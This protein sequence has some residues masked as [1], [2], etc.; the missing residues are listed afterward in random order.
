MVNDADEKV[1]IPGFYDDVIPL[2]QAERD[3]WAKLP[4]DEGRF[5]RD[6]KID[7]PLGEKG[8]SAIERSWARPTC[9]INGLTS[10][11]QGHGAKTIIPSTASAKVSMRLVPNQDPLKIG[12]S[13]EKMLR[14]LEPK[15]ATG[16]VM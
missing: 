4:F 8:Y 15:P 11:Y 2:S 10:G 1:T 12:D 14:D 6:L 13:F 3:A 7:A 16:P 5:L 9:D